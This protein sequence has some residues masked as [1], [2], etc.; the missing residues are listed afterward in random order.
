[1]AVFTVQ[2]AIEHLLFVT[3]SVPSEAHLGRLRSCVSNAMRAIATAKSKW[4]Y[5]Q[6]RRSFDL[7]PAVTTTGTFDPSD[8]SLAVSDTLPSWAERANVVIAGQRGHFPVASVETTTSLKLSYGPKVT[9]PIVLATVRLYQAEYVLPADTVSV[10]AVYR[11]IAGVDN[12]YVRLLTPQ[13]WHR[14]L[15]LAPNYSENT[16]VCTVAGS[17]RYLER[18][19]FLVAGPVSAPGG[20]IEYL[21]SRTL[22]PSQVVLDGFQTRCRQGTV[23][24]AENAVTGSGT[25]FTPD[26]VGCV[27]RLGNENPPTGM[28]GSNP[29]ISE[30]II[31]SVT[32]SQHLSLDSPIAPSVGTSCYTISAPIDIA[33]YMVEA[34][35][36]YLEFQAWAILNPQRVRQAA[37]LAH[38]ALRRA[39][40]ADAA[41]P[42]PTTDER[43]VHPVVHVV[44]VGS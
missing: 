21:A 38:E 35:T 20:R 27:F 19:S 1:V 3:D 31:T 43:A 29:P 17:P 30:R 10:S 9:S 44:H 2:D 14:Y 22:L 37:E 36:R 34:F 23:T 5:F 13:E 18:L 11:T 25:A 4:R 32:D 8:L 12:G 33:E 15:L 39:K 24:I 28:A 7:E 42:L 41:Y 6:V 16:V 40:A 26:M